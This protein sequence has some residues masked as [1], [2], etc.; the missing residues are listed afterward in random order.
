MLKIN[1]IGGPLDGSYEVRPTQ[2][3]D[4]E[5]VHRLIE[6]RFVTY[7]FNRMRSAFEYNQGQ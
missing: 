3:R 5:P 1:Y 6:D 2:P 7:L 4:R